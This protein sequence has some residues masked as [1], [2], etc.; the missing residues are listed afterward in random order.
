M[1]EGG[2]R[3]YFFNIFLDLILKIFPT[4]LIL[5]II[6]LVLKKKEVEGIKNRKK[7]WR[8]FLP[9]ILIIS[10]VGGFLQFFHLKIES[11][12][13]IKGKIGYSYLGASKGLAPNKTRLDVDEIIGDEVLKEI[14]DTKEFGDISVEELKESLSVANANP[15]SNISTEN[16]YISA[17]YIVAYNANADTKGIDGQDLVIKIAEKYRDFFQEK[18][19]RKT[20]LL[21]ADFSQLEN[22]NYLDIYEY[23]KVKLNNISNYMMKCKE[24]NG[25]Y[26]SENTGE[27]FGSLEERAN[28]YETTALERYR[29]FLL[30]NGICNDKDDY[31]SRLN[32][33]NRI[34]EIDYLKN[35]ASYNVMI[36]AI[37]KYDKDIIRSVLVP[38][39]DESG[40]FYQSRTKIGT[41]TF[42]ESAN[43]YL[44]IATK[45]KLEID[46]NQSEI[47]RLKSKTATTAS[48]EKADKM[49]D[50]MK[51][52]IS[53][54]SQLAIDTVKDYDAERM[55]NYINF[56]IE[57]KNSD[58]IRLTIYAFIYAVIIFGFLSV[59]IV[60][61]G[62][63]KRR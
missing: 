48:Y 14:V 36:D 15:V 39:R 13:N 7:R 25:S 38:T 21:N 12:L 11:G 29:S 58:F 16:Q 24:E 56:S 23:L 62:K 60:L 54:I 8:Y 40:E 3:M 41:D 18:Y 31:I 5:I 4:I 26:I 33:Q 35:S 10:L 43:E 22:A 46:T 17:E 52:E 6:F 37:E 50:E 55:K 9:F 61:N 34:L 42:A 45:T 30:E 28:T 63:I 19:G 49:I 2:I 1:K 59:I 44:K 47:D 53:S 51:T 27:S 57:D 20:D 32:Y